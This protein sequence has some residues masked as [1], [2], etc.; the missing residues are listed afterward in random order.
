MLT[1]FQLGRDEPTFSM[2][3]SRKLIY[4]RNQ[5]VISGNLQTIPDTSTTFTDGSRVPLSTKEISSTEIFATSL[6]HS[7]KRQNK[8]N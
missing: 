3:P 7:P 1:V 5:N 2:D 8:N 4:T 6:V